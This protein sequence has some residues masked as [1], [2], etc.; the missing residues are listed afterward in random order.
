MRVEWVI[1]FAKIKEPCSLKGSFT[2]FLYNKKVG[3]RNETL[4]ESE[5]YCDMPLA[6]NVQKFPDIRIF[7]ITETMVN[8]TMK[9][10]IPPSK[11]QSVDDECSKSYFDLLIEHAKF[12]KGNNQSIFVCVCVKTSW[13]CQQKNKTWLKI[14]LAICQT[15]HLSL[16]GVFY[17]P[18]LFSG[19]RPTSNFF[20]AIQSQSS[21]KW[22]FLLEGR[23]E[24][25][26]P[27]LQLCVEGE[28]ENDD[29]VA[30]NS[31][32]TVLNIYYLRNSK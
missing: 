29:S 14:F 8:A 25:T 10:K 21:K 22:S 19:V 17:E 27:L 9:I 23:R 1:F 12:A 15:R 32:F 7:I 18:V 28:D 5:K 11:A 26:K 2:F 6:I 30:T 4:S 24:I 31:L 20:L 16:S 13:K 3:G